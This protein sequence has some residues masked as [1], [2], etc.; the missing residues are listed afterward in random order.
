MQH[1]IAVLPTEK[2]ED[3]TIEAFDSKIAMLVSS[4]HLMLAS[5]VFN[6]MLS[7]RFS[8]GAMLQ[9]CGKVDIPIFDDDREAL[10][11]VLNIIHGHPKKVPRSIDLV[12]MTRVSILVDK[13]DI[14]EAVEHFADLWIKKLVVKRLPSCMD[15]TLLPWICIAWVF[16]KQTVFTSVTRIAK[17]Y[18]TEKLST[19]DLP[20]PEKVLGESLSSSI[21]QIWLI[22]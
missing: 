13:Y 2:I 15:K 12:T 1:E 3:N 5:K 22:S 7:P 9:S 19:S 18:S 6:S 11:M 17:I 20:I 21:L 4:K 16:K 10:E 14:H 8:E